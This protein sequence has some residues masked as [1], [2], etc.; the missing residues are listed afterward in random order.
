MKGDQVHNFNHD[1]LKD[2]KIIFTIV[3]LK[4]LGIKIVEDYLSKD[5]NSLKNNG[6]KSYSPK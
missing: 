4:A 5:F 2:F 6:A 3:E 1:K